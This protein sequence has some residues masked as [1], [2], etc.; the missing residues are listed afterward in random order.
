M[1]SDDIYEMNSKRLNILEKYT[2]LKVEYNMD[3]LMEKVM[4]FHNLN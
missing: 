3:E 1:T 2:N 4:N